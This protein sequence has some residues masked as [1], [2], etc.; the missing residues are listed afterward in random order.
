MAISAATGMIASTVLGG[1]FGKGNKGGDKAQKQS[2]ALQAERLAMMKA[3]LADMQK[4]VGGMVDSGYFN[5]ENANAYMDALMN[6]AIA[7]AGTNMAAM[8]AMMGGR[9]GDSTT[10]DAS[11]GVQNEGLRMK[12]EAYAES[13]R[14]LPMLEMQA[15]SALNPEAIGLGAAFTGASNAQQNLAQFQEQTRQNP[16][17]FYQAVMPFAAQAWG[18][19]GT[20]AGYSAQTDFS[21]LTPAYDYKANPYAN[22]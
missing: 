10:I 1:V 7:Q 3:Y 12:Q 11:V 20:N 18:Q 4:F 14:T 13:Y 22:K 15:R 16:A 17:A 9:P 8:N 21:G 5:P 6:P 2:V 19:G